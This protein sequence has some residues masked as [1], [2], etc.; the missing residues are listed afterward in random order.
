MRSE[1][2]AL[3]IS[4]MTIAYYFQDFKAGHHY[5]CWVMLCGCWEQHEWGSGVH[6]AIADS[7]RSFD[8]LFLSRFSCDFHKCASINKFQRE[9]FPLLYVYFRSYFGKKSVDPVS[10]F[11]E[12]TNSLNLSVWEFYWMIWG[13]PSRLN[14]FRKADNSL[15]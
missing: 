10:M 8:F 11:H 15:H 9:I 4:Q 1:Q 5:L 14:A 6:A 12:A 13:H 7:N 3:D 2:M